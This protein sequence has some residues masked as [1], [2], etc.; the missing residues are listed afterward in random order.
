MKKRSPIFCQMISLYEHELD[1]KDIFQ[2]DGMVEY[3]VV[4]TPIS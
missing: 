4:T 1:V 2:E 3:A